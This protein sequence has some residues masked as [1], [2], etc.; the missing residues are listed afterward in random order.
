ML[1]LE[2]HYIIQCISMHCIRVGQ[3][4]TGTLLLLKG[5]VLYG[6]HIQQDCMLCI[7]IL[8]T[9]DKMRFVSIEGDWYN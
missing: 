6:N 2:R 4:C 5:V 3:L 9:C 8:A 1:H 7:A